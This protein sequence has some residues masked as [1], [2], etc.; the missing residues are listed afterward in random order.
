VKSVLVMAGTGTAL[1][2]GTVVGLLGVQGRL[3]HDGTRGIPVLSMFFPAPPEEHASAD[4]TYAEPAAAAHAAPGHDAGGAPPRIGVQHQGLGNED[5]LPFRRGRSAFATEPPAGEHGGTEHGAKA[6][7][8][9]AGHEP[10]AA[11]AHAETGKLEPPKEE[12]QRQVESLLGQEKYR[13]GAYF[14]FPRLEGDL[15]VDQL[16]QYL[17]AARTALDDVEARRKAVDAADA[18]LA[19]RQRDI[20]D[21]ERAIADQMVRV[22]AER[23]KLD[24]R[25]KAFEDQVVLVRRDE[26]AGLRQ[27]AQTLASFE[28]R[29]A[30]QH[31]VD[32]WQSEEGRERILKVLAVMEPDAADAILA[33]V[34]VP[35]LK[36][37]LVERLK[38]VIERDKKP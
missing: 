1:F 38:V 12:F 34:E 24:E 23:R 22:D 6:P 33:Q 14:T 37:L 11:P 21:R 13:P 25:I 4:K 19:A 31:V 10:P 28:P 9:S 29:R 15:S 5:K 17:R 26:I 32:A 30:M 3:N 27:Y 18:E 20:E 16:N 2:A 7:E 8:A 35:K 36:D